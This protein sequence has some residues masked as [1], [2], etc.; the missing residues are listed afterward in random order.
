MR[1]SLLLILCASLCQDGSS[2]TTVYKKNSLQHPNLTAI[3]FPNHIL[4]FDQWHDV[5]EKPYVACVLHNGLGNVLFSIAGCLAYSK[6][7]S[8]PLVL[9]YWPGRRFRRSN[10][11][12]WGGHPSPFGNNVTLGHIFN[13][14]PWKQLTSHMP[15]DLNYFRVKGKLPQHAPAEFRA[16]PLV[17]TKATFVEGWFFTTIEDEYNRNELREL[18]GLNP[19]LANYWDQQYGDLLTN[20]TAISVHMRLG[21]H[22]EEDPNALAAR[23]SPE[24]NYYVHAMAR[25]LGDIPAPTRYLI[26]ADDVDKA[27]ELLTNAPELSM[28]DM[29]IIPVNVIGALHLMTL[30]Q[31]HVLATSSLSFWGAYLAADPGRV[32][33]H[34]S[35]TLVHGWRVLPSDQ[36][37]LGERWIVVSNATMAK[38][39]RRNKRE[40]SNAKTDIQLQ[41]PQDAPKP[42]VRRKPIRIRSHV[43]AA[44]TAM[45]V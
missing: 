29:V 43:L 39:E 15:A 20:V 27:E 9:G 18:F 7:V 8:R 38:W 41:D 44:M 22:G 25:L 40:A 16:L 30:C 37:E 17:I 13:R 6:R 12:E 34:S 2:T 11:K 1:S 19:L 14:L 45:T 23:P 4:T 28:L 33:Y 35:L 5:S 42:T 24:M 10:Y 26:F 32:I 3:A 31:H 21:Y 36:L